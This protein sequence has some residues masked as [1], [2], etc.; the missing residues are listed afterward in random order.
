MN[1]AQ[2]SHTQTLDHMLENALEG[3][4]STQCLVQDIR[5]LGQM[6]YRRFL[7]LSKALAQRCR[8][9]LEDVRLTWTDFTR[10]DVDE[11]RPNTMGYLAHYIMCLDDSY[12]SICARE[13]RGALLQAKHDLT[14]ALIEPMQQCLD[15]YGNTGFNTPARTVRPAQQATRA[16]RTHLPGSN[17][18]PREQRALVNIFV[19]AD[20]VSLEV[21]YQG[22]AV[23]A[24]DDNLANTLDD[25][26]KR[27]KAY[28]STDCGAELINRLKRLRCMHSETAYAGA[29]F[30]DFV[31]PYIRPLALLYLAKI[32]EQNEASNPSK[33]LTELDQRIQTA[34]AFS[35]PRNR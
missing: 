13:V 29:L 9:H 24:H 34:L 4:V 35:T 17:L 10:P 25:N 15:S 1:R 2:I 30:S 16:N 33:P 11:T 6:D 22:L 32:F 28:L 31:Y 20:I 3:T 12:D 21:A 7:G 26:A 18:S 27:T 8:K 19:R 23:A 5:I 14:L